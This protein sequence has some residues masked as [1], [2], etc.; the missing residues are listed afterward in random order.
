MSI[1]GCIHRDAQKQ[2]IDLITADH[3]CLNT[4]SY[5][6]SLLMLAGI[7]IYNQ[8]VHGLPKNQALHSKEELDMGSSIMSTNSYLH[9]DASLTKAT[10]ANLIHI[11]IWWYNCRFIWNATQIGSPLF[12]LDACRSYYIVWIFYLVPWI[13]IFILHRGMYYING[14]YSC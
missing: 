10:K 7:I 8:L 11:A 9:L 5:F 12:L 13:I 1:W 14:W 6:S 2:N 3:L 4:L